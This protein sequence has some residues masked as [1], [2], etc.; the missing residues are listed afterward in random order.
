MQL[1]NT[2]TTVPAGQTKQIKFFVPVGAPGFTALVTWDAGDPE[3]WLLP[4]SGK[5]ITT[6]TLIGTNARR[7]KV[8]GPQNGIWRLSATAD[9]DTNVDLHFTLWKTPG[10]GANNMFTYVALGDSY[11]AGEGVDP[12][13]RDGTNPDT[14]EQNIYNRCHRSSQAY[15][16]W[17]QRPYDTKPLYATASGGG[18]PGSFGGTNKYA[19]DTNIRSAKDVTW[20]FWACSGARTFVNILPARQGG[21]PQAGSGQ[22]W[23]GKTQLDERGIEDVDLITI[24]IGGNDVGFVEIVT[25][26]A[27]S[28]CAT[29]K[30]EAE[31]K[32]LMDETQPELVKVYKAIRKQAPG[33]RILVLGY[34]H[35]FPP[36]IPT[37][38]TLAPWAGETQMLRRLD[39]YMN[40]RIEAAAK[41]AKVEFVP[42]TDWFDDHEVCGAKGA[43]INPFHVTPKIARK[44]AND[45]VVPSDPHGSAVRLRSRRQR[46]AQA[47]ALA[48]VAS[49]RP[50]LRQPRE[51]A[52]PEPERREQAVEQ[53]QRDRR[54]T[55]YQSGQRQSQGPAASAS[56]Q[57]TPRSRSRAALYVREPHRITTYV[58]GPAAP[59]I[60]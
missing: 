12:Y 39:A 9:A 33:A 40:A 7:F 2:S 25:H 22:Y 43:W 30:Y 5:T 37:C 23:D 55:K 56:G 11:L 4:P 13:F 53:H 54:G 10:V 41:T 14:G 29:S 20:V 44:G 27:L 24:T 49:P 50:E 32:K 47:E 19:R 45:E 36:G 15:A 16:E 46:C 1:A 8:S 18:K 28:L 51:R 21:R 59:G 31:R 60:V 17:V 42:V 52:Q 58:R 34:P 26:C 38:G 3:L 6:S 48:P 57:R 35:L